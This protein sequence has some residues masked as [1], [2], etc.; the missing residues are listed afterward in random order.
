MGLWQ[1][2]R[3]RAKLTWLRR[4]EYESLELRQWFARDFGVEVGLYSYGCFD[5]WRVPPRTRIGRYC[6]FAK[7]VRIVDMDHPPSALTTHPFVY[8]QGGHNPLRPSWLEIGDDV[9][10][11]HNA[12]ILPGC[13][14]IG[15]GA[16]IGAGALVTR[17]VPAYAIVVGVPAKVVRL[18][19]APDLVDAIEASRW[20]EMSRTEL[21]ELQR[22]EPEL[23]HAPTAASLSRLGALA[24]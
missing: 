4:D 20:W 14:S 11:G 23:I 21:A 1:S 15:R 22:R 7:T 10:V 3:Y 24:A 2:L 6:S 9:W 17:D 5:R 12:T 16:I 13:G 19:F 18:R 8:Q